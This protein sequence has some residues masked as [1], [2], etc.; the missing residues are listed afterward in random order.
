MD[1]FGGYDRTDLAEVSYDLP[2][3]GC[4]VELNFSERRAVFLIN[5]YAI[6]KYD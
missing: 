2:A 5:C 4:K 1:L 6:F 3:I